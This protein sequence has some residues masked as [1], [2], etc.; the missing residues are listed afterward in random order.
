MLSRRPSYYVQVAE[1]HPI[2]EMNLVFPAAAE[3]YSF[4]NDVHYT[5]ACAE[6]CVRG[7]CN[8]LINYTNEIMS[9][10]V[11]VQASW[12]H[13]LNT[14]RPAS[15]F[16]FVS[17]RIRAFAGFIFSV[18]VATGNNVIYSIKYLKTVVAGIV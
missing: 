5:S 11:V 3:S 12:S 1:H 13:H 7:E 15:D 2:I 17:T 16:A 14:N 9:I 10:P 4:I 18:C 6:R 8:K